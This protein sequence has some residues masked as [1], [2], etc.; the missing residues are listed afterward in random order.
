MVDGNTKSLY[1]VHSF[2]HVQHVLS[3]KI[4]TKGFISNVFNISIQHPLRV[5][6]KSA[7]FYEI[8][9]FLELSLSLLAPSL[10]LSVSGSQNL[11]LCN[12]KVI[13]FCL[14][15]LCYMFYTFFDLFFREHLQ[16]KFVLNLKFSRCK[17]LYEENVRKKS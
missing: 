3:L 4:N 13:F 6:C 17:E 5:A 1:S 12:C 2:I 14:Y 10:S 7:T 9:I 16:V 11:I 8:Y 15:E